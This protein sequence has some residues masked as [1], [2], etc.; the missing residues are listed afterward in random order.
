MQALGYITTIVFVLIVACSPGAHT[1]QCGMMGIHWGYR[2]SLPFML[3]SATGFFGVILLSAF[4]AALLDSFL[5]EVVMFVPI[6]AAAYIFYLAWQIRMSR[7][8][9]GDDW[10]ARRPGYANGLVLQLRNPK[11]I[12]LGLVLYTTFLGELPLTVS[13]CLL[14]ALCCTAISFSAG[15]IW[16]LFGKDISEHLKN[17][18]RRNVV[19]TILALLLAALAI[20]LLAG[21]LPSWK[22]LMSDPPSS[23]VDRLMLEF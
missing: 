21:V 4:V 11:V 7:Y 5:P 14:S 9:L 10:P 16:V 13:S 12:V 22:Q 19:N 23:L 6:A 3:G 1:I 15:S 8:A 2:K 18:G 20:I 17:K